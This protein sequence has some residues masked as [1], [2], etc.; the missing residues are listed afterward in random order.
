M[1][2]RLVGI[3]QRDVENERKESETKERKEKRKVGK[4]KAVD[5]V[6]AEDN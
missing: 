4:D 6:E 3:F 1:V 5:V 2:V